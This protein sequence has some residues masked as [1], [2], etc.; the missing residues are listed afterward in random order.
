MTTEY[1]TEPGDRWDLIAYKAYGTVGSIIL[2]DGTQ[3]NAMSYIANSN[4]ELS[5]DDVL[6]PGL[7]MQI[8]IIQNMITPIDPTLQPPWK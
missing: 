6:S 4:P 5:V 7:L 8:P 2:D 1:I 3:V